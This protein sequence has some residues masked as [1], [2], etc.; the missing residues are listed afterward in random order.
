MP[1]TLKAGHVAPEFDLE[2]DR[3]AHTQL[4]G[5]RGTWVV[6]YWYRMTIRRAA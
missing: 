6:L 2:N 4:S 3:G 1:T 5:M